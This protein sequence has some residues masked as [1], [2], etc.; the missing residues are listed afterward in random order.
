MPAP[1]DTL[2]SAAMSTATPELTSP[3]AGHPE[4]GCGPAPGLGAALYLP[5]QSSEML[6]LEEFL[7]DSDQGSPAAVR[8]LGA[9][10][11]LTPSDG[12]GPEVGTL[13]TKSQRGMGL[14]VVQPGSDG[15]Q[16]H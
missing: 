5:E 12:P 2:P 16:N 11:S 8:G 13:T 14:G 10:S 7:E 15:E 9:L 1:Q 4:E 3:P 6:T